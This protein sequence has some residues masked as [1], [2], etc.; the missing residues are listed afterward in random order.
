MKQKLLNTMAVFGLLTFTT[1]A[2]TLAL[3]IN[4]VMSIALVC[5]V[6]QD[7]TG[8]TNCK[9]T[10]KSLLELIATDQGFTLPAK[11]K[12]WS[13]DDAFSVLNADDT[14]FTNI[15]TNLLNITYVTAVL[16]SKLT[17]TTNTY[18]DTINGSSVIILNYNGSSVSFT[19]N[20]YGK[21]NFLNKIKGTNAVA[22]SSFSGDGFGSGICDGQDMVVKGSLTGK[23][24]MRYTVRYTGD[25][26]L[27]IFPH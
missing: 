26:G 23:Y 14:I 13:S 11:A 24:S 16:K 8:V 18:T 22:S 21:Q 1:Q 2:Q 27:G 10:T 3:A 7:S 20:C 17:Q 19:F 4:N 15:D 5:Q 9:I 12:L 6:Q 25:G